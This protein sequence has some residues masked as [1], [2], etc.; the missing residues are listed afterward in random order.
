MICIDTMEEVEDKRA[1]TT[2]HIKLH[3]REWG[4]FRVLKKMN[5]GQSIG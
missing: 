3:A 2:V 1:K 4:N 5:S